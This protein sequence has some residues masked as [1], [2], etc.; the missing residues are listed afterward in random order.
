M[1]LGAGTSWTYFGAAANHFRL[2]C[3]VKQITDIT[4]VV[5]ALRNGNLVISSQS[6]GLFTSGGHYIVLSGIDSNGG[7][8]VKDPN[9]NNAVT[10]GYNNRTF[11]KEEI[12]Q[13]AKQYWIFYKK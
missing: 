12:D 3:T 1:F 6:A 2:N 8:I 13:A 7:I 11:S 9:K 10:K 5:E 4:T